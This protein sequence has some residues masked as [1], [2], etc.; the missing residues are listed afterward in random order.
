VNE[1]IPLPPQLPA[2][3]LDLTIRQLIR[4]VKIDFIELGGLLLELY[5]LKSW[6]QC[7]F[8]RWQDYVESLGI[9]SYSY[10][11]S[12]VAIS[13]LVADKFLTSEDVLEI[14]YS[15]ACLLA[16]VAARGELTEELVSLARVSTNRDL[17]L[18]LGHRVREN[19]ESSS[20][21]CPSCG[22][23]IIGCVWKKKEDTKSH[24]VENEKIY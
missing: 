5:D 12:L 19:D 20:V 24:M 1:I 2:E 10:V 3:R 21:H 6:S 17:R 9:G 14:G 11:M 15:K 8:D 23:T 18:Q 16:P 7:G 22:A 4:D 13:K